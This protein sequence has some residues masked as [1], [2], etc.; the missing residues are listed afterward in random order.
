MA[1]AS[2]ISNQKRE[3]PRRPVPAHLQGHYRLETTHRNRRRER[4][5]FLTT[6]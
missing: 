4:R 6:L 5:Y 2:D 1:A 3:G